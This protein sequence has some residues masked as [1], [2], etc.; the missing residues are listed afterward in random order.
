MSGL[1]KKDPA[2]MNH[3]ELWYWATH[4]DQDSVMASAVELGRLGI[5]RQPSG[6]SG[7]WKK[8]KAGHTDF[9]GYSDNSAAIWISQQKMHVRFKIQALPVHVRAFGQVMYGNGGELEYKQLHSHLYREV[10]RLLVER[11]PGMSSERKGLIWA[12]LHCAIAH[13]WDAI[14]PAIEGGRPRDMDISARAA[15]VAMADLGKDMDVSQ[16][17]R[18]WRPVWRMIIE[19]M[20]GVDDEGEASIKEER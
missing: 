20:R 9:G 2:K 15:K 12:L 16:W 6:M 18:Q 10:M 1:R 4:E 14:S 19:V 8:T 3:R 5:S 17:R 11:F 7:G 13:Y